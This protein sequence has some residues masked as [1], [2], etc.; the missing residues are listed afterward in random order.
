VLRQQEL[1]R[2]AVSDADV[3]YTVGLRVLPADEH[4]WGAIGSAKG[5]IEYVGFEPDHFLSWADAKGRR[6]VH[7]LA[8]SFEAAL[9]HIHGRIVTS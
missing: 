9:P 2:E 5:A 7:V 6:N 3:I 8:K 1:W 4:I